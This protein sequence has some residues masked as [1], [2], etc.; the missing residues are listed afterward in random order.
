MANISTASWAGLA[1]RQVNASQH[2]VLSCAGSSVG[3][4]CVELPTPPSFPIRYDPRLLA[5][6]DAR[7]DSSSLYMCRDG[8]NCLILVL[9]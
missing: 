2:I 1:E 9:T 6:V 5:C 7:E 8:V 3:I 4:E